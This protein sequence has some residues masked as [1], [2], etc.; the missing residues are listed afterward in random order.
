MYI[1]A[2][3]DNSQFDP[4]MVF[5]EEERVAANRVVLQNVIQ[6][7][8]GYFSSPEMTEDELKDIYLEAVDIASVT[9]AV[10]GMSIVGENVN[11]HFVAKFNPY[12]S[13]EDFIKQQEKLKG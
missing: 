5:E 1:G 12:K 4:V 10:A 8:F 6:V 11:G 3:S 7:L 9:M 13:I 2:M